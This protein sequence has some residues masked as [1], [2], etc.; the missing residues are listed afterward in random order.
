MGEIIQKS[1]QIDPLGLLFPLVREEVFDVLLR[2]ADAHVQGGD[3]V[4]GGH[5]L[6]FR[7]EPQ[8]GPGVALGEAEALDGSQDLGAVDTIG[9][10]KSAIISLFNSDIMA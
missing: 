2:A 1:P 8:Q 4:D 10:N 3:G 6:L 7:G 9:V 5:F